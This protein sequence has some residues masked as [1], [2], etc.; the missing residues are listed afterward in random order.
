V[1]RVAENAQRIVVAEMNLGQMALEVE[2]IVGRGKVLRVGRADGQMVTPDQI[3]DA[4]RA[5]QGQVSLHRV[6]AHR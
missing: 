2:R 4:M 1:E 5:S 3:V 6:P